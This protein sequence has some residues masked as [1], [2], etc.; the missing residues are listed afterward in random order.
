PLTKVYFREEGHPTL[1][2]VFAKDY[3]VTYRNNIEVGTATMT[4]HGKVAY[5]GQV[6]VKFNIARQ[7][8]P[9]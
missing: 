8:E 9:E 5:R 1:E 6:T 2:L 3:Y 4:I 7:P